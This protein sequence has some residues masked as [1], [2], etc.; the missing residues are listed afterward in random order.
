MKVY[1]DKDV[2]LSELTDF[3][4]MLD[5]ENLT[6]SIWKIL[7][8]MREGEI[9]RGEVQP[10]YYLENDKEAIEKFSLDISKPLYFTIELIN[11]A[12]IVD[13]Y[14]D[15]T[16]F[17]RTLW[18]GFSWS[19]YIESTVQFRMMLVINGEIKID[20]MLSEEELDTHTAWIAEHATAD[21]KPDVS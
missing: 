4:G 18:R 3:T 2:I 21:P 20:N 19:P 11:F 1:Q 17:K 13:W 16:A 7:E 14:L 15:K 6:P 12:T 5:H 10:S 8:T 9:A